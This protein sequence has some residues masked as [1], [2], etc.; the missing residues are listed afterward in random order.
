MQQAKVITQD[1]YAAALQE[2]L[3]LRKE[4]SGRMD[5]YALTA[6]TSK[7]CY[8]QVLERMLVSL[9]GE[10]DVYRKGG[11][12]RTTLEKS[13]QNELNTQETSTQNPSREPSGSIPVILQGK[14]IRAIVCGEGREADV[15]SKLESLGISYIGYDVGVISLEAITREQ[16]IETADEDSAAN[17][18]S[19]QPSP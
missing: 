7:Q 12:I 11:T 16:I 13:L 19:P 18:S 8:Q 9:I 17:P 1:E 2:P 5:L 15:R 4:G 14:K 6:G 10:H 3:D